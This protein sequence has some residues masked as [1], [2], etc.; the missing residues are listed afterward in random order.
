M[1][2]EDEKVANAAFSW[3]EHC[4]VITYEL[5]GATD[6]VNF[7]RSRC[8]A[9]HKALWHNNWGGLPPKEFLSLLDPR[10]A[11][12]RDRLYKDTYTSDLPAGKLSKV[13]ADKL[14]LSTDT[15]ISVGTFDAHAGAIGGKITPNTLVKVMGTSTCDIMVA[16]YDEIGENLVQGICGQVDGS[17]IPNSIGLEAGQSGFGDVL[18]WFRD[19]ISLPAISIIKEN[20]NLEE[21]IKEQII[22]D[23]REGILNQLSLEALEIPLSESSPVALDWINGRRTPDANQSLKGAIMGLNPGTDAARFFKALVESIC[24]G[25]KKIIERFREEGIQIDAVIGMG[26]VAKKS[27]L[28][29]QTMADVLDMPIKISAS[30]QTPALGAAMYAAVASGLYPDIPSAISAMGADFDEVYEPIKENTLIYETLYQKYVDF[31]G[32]VEANS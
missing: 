21:K 11:T 28:V 27:K 23:L 18:A 16:S 3:M 15:V 10:L 30:D 5:I 9:G 22:T 26:G 6:P 32:F 2:R 25:S 29:M 4:D 13:W 20:V 7:K 8:A 19:L 14:G 24:F 12:L 1:I 17:V 31:G